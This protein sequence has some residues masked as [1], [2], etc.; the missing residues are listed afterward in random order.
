MRNVKM[1]REQLLAVNR[2]ALWSRLYGLIWL[3]FAQFIL[4]ALIEVAA[5]IV[6]LHFL[7]GL[8]V[9][10]LAWTNYTTIKR[11]QAPNRII[12]ISK[13]TAILAVVQILVGILNYGQMMLKLGAPLGTVVNILHLIIALAI[14]SQASS[15]AT[16]YDMWEEKEFVA[17]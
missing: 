4:A 1:F 8:G 7:V 14:L 5:F 2:L 11:T 6:Y 12:R 3:A 16:A 13:T 15:T 17:K 10:D 9:L